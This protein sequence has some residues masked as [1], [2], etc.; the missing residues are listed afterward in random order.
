[1]YEVH[2]TQNR[3]EDLDTQVAGAAEI[4]QDITS[5]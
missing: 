4:C 1:M 2:I 5:T 3:V